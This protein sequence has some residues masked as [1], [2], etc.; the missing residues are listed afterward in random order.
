MDFF[1]FYKYVMQYEK[2][3]NMGQNQPD[4]LIE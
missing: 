3:W 2:R 1:P 4:I